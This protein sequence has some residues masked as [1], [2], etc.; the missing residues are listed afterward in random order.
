MRRN[1]TDTEKKQEERANMKDFNEINY[2]EDF[3]KDI[4]FSFLQSLVLVSAYICG[5]NKESMDI[6][7]FEARQETQRK[8][9]GE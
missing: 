9:K 1:Q 7:M 4:N 2:L 5:I 8:L 6:R 3:Q